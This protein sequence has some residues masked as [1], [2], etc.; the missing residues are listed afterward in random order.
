M[1]VPRADAARRIGERIEL[2][3]QMLDRQ[4]NREQELVELARDF[5]SWHDYND[6]LLLKLFTTPAIRDR[7]LPVTFSSWSPDPTRRL[8]GVRRDIQGLQ[9]ELES[10]L[11]RLDLYDEP[12]N[13]AA[14]R[15][16]GA[17]NEANSTIFVVHGHDEARKLEVAGFIERI[18]GRRPTILHEQP[19]RGRTI[20]EKFEDHAGEAGFAVVLLTGD[21]VGGVD[22][23]SLQRRARQNVVL[24]LGFFMGALGR[25]HVVALYEEGVELPSDLEGV[26]YVPFATVWQLQL[27]SEMKAAGIEV[28]LNKALGA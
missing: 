14:S 28:D 19:N 18:A 23:D 26:L 12:E 24:E 27:A 6:A 3:Q 4:I 8:Q 20:I 22:P 21:D 1:R 2:G 7:Y 25:G 16:G 15:E 13:V 9:H 5:H 17:V 10:I 11:G